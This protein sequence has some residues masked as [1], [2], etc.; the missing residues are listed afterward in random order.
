M[1]CQPAIDS[2]GNVTVE[3]SFNS[4]VVGKTTMSDVLEKCG[5]P[6]LHCDNYSWIYVGLKTEEDR[7]K[8]VKSF[9]DFIVKITFNPD[10]TL[11]LIERIDPTNRR[12]ITM[13]KEVTRLIEEKQAVHQIKA[14]L[15]KKS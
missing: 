9:Y 8:N 3:E 11:K 2:R 13:D 12:E 10:R 1:A 7:F 5:T 6:S 14:A 15:A 4:F